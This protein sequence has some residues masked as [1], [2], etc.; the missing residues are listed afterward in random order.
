ML[1]FAL[2][3]ALPVTVYTLVSDN[4]DPREQAA[5]PDQT[6]SQSD[7]NSSA[8]SIDSVPVTEIRVGQKYDYFVR[9]SD[10]DGD[11]LEYFVVSKP[12]WLT[13][14]EDMKVL[15]GT[16]TNDDIGDSYVEISVSDGKWLDEQKFNISVLSD[17]S[18]DKNT[19]EGEQD[20][21]GSSEG[22]GNSINSDD[23]LENLN[24]DDGTDNDS[25]DSPTSASPEQY[26]IISGPDSSRQNSNTTI[27][28]GSPGYSQSQS[29]GSVLGESDDRLPD[30]ALDAT[31]VTLSAGFAILCVSLFFYL[32]AKMNLMSLLSAR[33]DY[34]NGEQIVVKTSK[35]NIIKKRRIEL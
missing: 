34:S 21:D 7:S 33:V 25:A 3:F 19:A 32:D 16:P 8:P 1:L 9:V 31:V 11:E 2:A 26:G 24:G 22:S 23:D 30:T 12:R 28:Q 20:G 6:A 29:G 35:G 5:E 18:V 10:A 15:E 4:V 13:W 17:S 27:S 14:D